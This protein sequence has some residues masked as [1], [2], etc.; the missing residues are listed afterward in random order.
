MLHCIYS[1]TILPLELLY[2]ALY[3][4][5][6]WL[7]GSYGL[8]LL[9]L[10]FASTMFFKPLKTLAAGV[11]AQEKLV[12]QVMA[13]QIAR[14]K[15]ESRGA[16]RQERIAN[17]YKRYSYHPLKSLRSSFGV[18]LQVPFLC[19]AYYMLRSYQPIAGQ[20]WGPIADLSQPDALLHGINLLPLV[21]T[22]INIGAVFTTQGFSRRERINAIAL[23][24]G[25]LLLLY[26]APS[27]LLVYWTTNNLFTLLGN[28]H[29]LLR[30]TKQ[31][32]LQRA[33]ASSTGLFSKKL[34][35]LD[36]RIPSTQSGKLYASSVLAAGVLFFFFGPAQLYL[37][38]PSSFSV[39]LGA[40]LY[41]IL[42][43][44]LAWVFVALL[45]WVAL[46]PKY[47]ALA[48]LALFVVALLCG[49]NSVL[50][51]G[52]YG[53]LDMAA[54]SKPDP[55]Y[56]TKSLFHD[57][58]IGLGIALV[59]ALLLW[60]RR[61]GKVAK[62]LQSA[63]FVLLV[64]I[65][66]N[67]GHETLQLRAA[68]KVQEATNKAVLQGYADFTQLSSTSPNVI[69]FVL[70]MF[71]G[72]H[73]GEIF[74]EYPELKTS[75]DG[76]TWYPDT[77]AT[78]SA[79][80][81]SIASLYGGPEFEPRR[82]NERSNITLHQT[83]SEAV[84]A[85][86]AAL[87]KHGVYSSFLDLPFTL[88]EQTFWKLADTNKVHIYNTAPEQAI[89]N[90]WEKK[91]V[92]QKSLQ[93]AHYANY[94]LAVSLFRLSPHSLKKYVYNRGQWLPG[95]LE[96][97]TR[98]PYILYQTGLLGLLPDYVTTK[99]LPPTLKIQYSLLPH[100]TWHL[101]KDSLVPVADPYPETEGQL[102]TIDGLLPE[103]IYTEKHI[104]ALLGT[105]FDKLRELGVF[106]NTMIILVSDHDEADSRMLNSALGVNEM[107]EKG[108]WGQNNA[109]PGRPHALL[110]V[111]PFK[112]KEPLQASPALMS[113]AD[114]PAL[115]CEATPGCEDFR[116]PD[117]GPQRVREHAVGDWKDMETQGATRLNIR[118]HVRV[119]GSM[120]NKE[121][122]S[123]EIL[124]PSIDPL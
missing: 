24:F 26:Q 60:F 75:F 105:Y 27:A 115:I 3:G 31:P 29:T 74:T 110:M 97:V 106:D 40:N 81:I 93:E 53:S 19:A 2:Q 49:A 59:T 80:S 112:A 11:Q 87:G 72:G 94:L 107:G 46:A 122:W 25:F 58:L 76:F 63:S 50:F 36:Q 6:I 52:L 69:V 37:S 121:H 78:G 67:V 21:M 98:L 34:A 95:A 22:L 104:L 23:A 71:T 102:V 62:V 89:A 4:I 77:L 10:S 33:Q 91:L 117:T 56:S 65:A 114:V 118:E 79:T 43:Y 8:A 17:L 96:G 14:I 83:Y 35:W 99:A 9:C 68:A 92:L 86:P 20:S 85:M 119:R 13:P 109:Y 66:W 73:V 45:L 7:T 5:A 15:H 70:D 55:L 42:P 30:G 113:I 123:S 108:R 116:L 90:A 124:D 61:I 57:L 120:F 12:Q 51:T 82:I 111:K 44:F 54:L 48:A 28:I 101:P 16:E 39:P 100:Y 88:D 64:Y 103:H 1:I 18:L 84:A 41:D 47:K 38:D 32:A